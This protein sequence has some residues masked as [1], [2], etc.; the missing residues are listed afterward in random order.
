MQRR[1]LT[2]AITVVFLIF[3]SVPIGFIF[4]GGAAGAI[5]GFAIICVLMAIQAP[6]FLLMK[7]MGMLPTRQ[8][9]GEKSD[10]A[11]EF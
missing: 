8:D 9:L 11:N 5:G 3:F 7:K 10:D 1:F 6:A 4:Y 2:S